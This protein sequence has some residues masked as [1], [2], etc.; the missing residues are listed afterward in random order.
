MLLLRRRMGH[1]AFELEFLDEV[2]ETIKGFAVSRSET[3]TQVEAAPAARK[4][5]SRH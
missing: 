1:I 3:A 4:V 2:E 5:R